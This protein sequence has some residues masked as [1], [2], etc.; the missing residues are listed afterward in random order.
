[1]QLRVGAFLR[2]LAEPEPQ[3]VARLEYQ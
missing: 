2:R 3:P 1:M